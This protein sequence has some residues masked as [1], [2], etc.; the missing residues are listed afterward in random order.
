MAWLF[1]QWLVIYNNKILPKYTQILSHTKSTHKNGLN[2]VKSGDTECNESF[3][4]C[5]VLNNPAMY[6]DCSLN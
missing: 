4:Q 1:L 5:L 3:K 6:L 2:L